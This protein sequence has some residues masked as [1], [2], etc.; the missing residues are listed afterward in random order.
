MLKKSAS[1]LKVKAEAKVELN[2]S[3]SSLTRIPTAAFLA[4]PM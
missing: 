2:Q 3:G 1:F 4:R